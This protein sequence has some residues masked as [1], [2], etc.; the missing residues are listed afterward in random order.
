M[1]NIFLLLFSLFSTNTFGQGFLS[2]DTLDY[3][4]KELKE[5][6]TS[7]IE[8][9][10]S[11]DIDGDDQNDFIVLSQSEE[12][13]IYDEY[14]V[15][16]DLR[17]WLTK[18]TSEKRIQYVKFLNIDNDPE[19]E[20]YEASGYE[21][22]IDYLL[23]DLN[24]EIGKQEILF[25][26]NPII[27]EDDKYYWGYPWDIMNMLVKNI[28]GELKILSSLDHDIIREGEVTFPDDQIIFPCIFFNGTSTQQNINVEEIRDIKWRTVEEIYETVHNR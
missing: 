13:Y 7:K 10:I 21:D 15:S 4:P 22:G 12:K 17:I 5:I 14:W 24:L 25:F 20:V 18:T 3:I 9:V 1:K 16:S 23:Y 19:M 8:R 2:A 26:F 11:I 28:D 27:L 6:I